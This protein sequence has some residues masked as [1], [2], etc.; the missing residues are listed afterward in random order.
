ESRAALRDGSEPAEDLS[1]RFMLSRR[2]RP[3]SRWQNWRTGRCGLGRRLLG[4][5]GIELGDGIVP[6][7]GRRVLLPVDN[8]CRAPIDLPRWPCQS[9]AMSREKCALLVGRVAS[10]R[11]VLGRLFSVLVLTLGFGSLGAKADWPEFRGPWGDGHALAPGSTKVIGL[12]L[13][14]SETNN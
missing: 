12:P 2:S 5:G 6:H 8:R 4:F 11:L 14:W 3:A 13:H 10:S 7:G 1:P 9:A